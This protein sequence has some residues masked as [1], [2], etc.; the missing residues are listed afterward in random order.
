M[1]FRVASKIIHNLSISFWYVGWKQV[2]AVLQLLKH[3]TA[4][5][6]VTFSKI[7]IVHLEGKLLK[8][9]DVLREEKTFQQQVNLYSSGTKQFK[10]FRKSL[11][12]TRFTRS[13]HP[14][15]YTS[16]KDC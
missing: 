5:F 2:G 1:T 8:T 7:K 15:A 12:L 10:D 3:N 11:K 16:I 6:L 14:Q 4:T 13:F 9:K